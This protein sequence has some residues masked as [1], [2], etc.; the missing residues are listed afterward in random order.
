MSTL[1]SI[2]IQYSKAF[3]LNVSRGLSK[4]LKI[5]STAQQLKH[6]CLDM[7]FPQNKRSRK[8]EG[9]DTALCVLRFVR[10]N[11]S[12]VGTSTANHLS[13]MFKAKLAGA[14]FYVPFSREFFEVVGGTVACPFN[15]D[16]DLGELVFSDD[17]SGQGL[18][19]KY[20]AQVLSI[21]ERVADT[22]DSLPEIETLRLKT[23]DPN[24]YVQ[25]LDCPRFTNML[26]NH[27]TS[28][29]NFG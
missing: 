8:L 27:E 17:T 7:I 22:V 14:G 5:C 16:D 19:Q 25:L 4:I 9:L 20:L 3:D 18:M 15:V 6:F 1:E 11:F 26:R 23:R 24:G 10:K 28:T 21:Y 13:Y 12:K 29:C 2:T